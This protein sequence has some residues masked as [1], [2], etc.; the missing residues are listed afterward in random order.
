MDG[1]SRGRVDRGL[2]K[3]DLTM[4]TNINRM[5]MP[6]P[7]VIML[8]SRMAALEAEIRRLEDLIAVDPL[9]KGAGMEERGWPGYMY[10]CGKLHDGL[11]DNSKPYVKVIMSSVP[12]VEETDAEFPDPMPPN[13][14]WIVKGD[15]ADP[16][17][18]TRF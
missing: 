11:T 14:E 15:H 5:P 4:P 16:V 13:E 18:I 17:H 3:E 7:S 2:P 6:D 12:T 1:R 8:M 10:V 9:P